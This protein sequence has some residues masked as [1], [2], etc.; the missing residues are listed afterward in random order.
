MFDSGESGGGGGGVVVVVTVK[1]V[2]YLEMIPVGHW[3]LVRL[4][5]SAECYLRSAA[6]CRRHL[7]E[8][9][10]SFHADH[11]GWGDS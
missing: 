1:E 5:A 8:L 7:E 3:L 4:P 11:A 2:H 9:Y 6:G 10:V